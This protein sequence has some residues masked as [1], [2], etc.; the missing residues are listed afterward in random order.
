[1]PKYLH[2]TCCRYSLHV[3]HAF[4]VHTNDHVTYPFDNIKQA[5]T[6]LV[7]LPNGGKGAGHIGQLVIRPL[8][9][10]QS[11]LVQN[12]ELL[13]SVIKLQAL[14]YKTH[15]QTDSWMCSGLPI[16]QTH[17]ASIVTSESA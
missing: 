16:I 15:V 13:G 1:M 7:V 6:L 2:R 3:P 12:P 4:H 5:F 9:R 8:P 10:D 11:I 14:S 17:T